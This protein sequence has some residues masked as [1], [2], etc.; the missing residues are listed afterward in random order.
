MTVDDALKIIGA[1]GGAKFFVTLTVLILGI[2]Y[3][4]PI[5]IAITKGANVILKRGD[6]QASITSNESGQKEFSQLE[7]E[8]A[9]GKTSK[10]EEGRFKEDEIEETITEQ[11]ND[12]DD[13]HLSKMLS[14]IRK[15]DKQTADA[16]LS[17]SLES[18]Q[19]PRERL[20]A[21]SLYYY[22]SFLSGDTS[23]IKGLNELLGQTDERADKAIV[24]LW[25]RTCLF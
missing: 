24:H 25:I 9:A 12:K 23:A 14:A 17:L 4:D 22:E 16:E 7:A 10:D 5:R 3:R 19:N 21:K 11:G 1:L 2:I 6:I 20:T 8:S 15:G 13:N 18:G